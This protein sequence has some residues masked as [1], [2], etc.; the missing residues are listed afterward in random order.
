MTVS[1]WCIG[2]LQL[3]AYGKESVTGKGVASGGAN[4][5]LRVAREIMQ[6]HMVMPY[7]VGIVV[8]KPIAP[9]ITPTT[10]AI[11]GEHDVPVTAREILDRGLV[12]K[13]QWKELVTLSIKLFARGREIAAENGL[14]LGDPKY[15]VGV[16]EAGRVTLADEIHTPDSSRY[17]IA[18]SYPQHLAKAREPESLD[19][20]FLR[21]WIAER[22]DPY[23]D[24]VLDIHADTLIEF[25]GKYIK[26]YEQITGRVFVPPDSNQ[27]VRARIEESLRG[28]FP[29]YFKG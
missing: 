27:P 15:E 10:K 22:C 1:V 5:K 12:S 13:E 14:I 20:E 11:Q 18:N 23:K 6:G 29:E 26:L 25:S 7:P 2:A 3:F 28:S 17:W 19:K 9:I 24:P 4:G 21:L 16:D 8:A